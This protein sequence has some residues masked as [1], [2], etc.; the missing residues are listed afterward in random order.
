MHIQATGFAPS[1]TS[2]FLR[3]IQRNFALHFLAARTID[4]FLFRNWHQCQ[5]AARPFISG[6]FDSVWTST[7]TSPS[8]CRNYHAPGTVYSWKPDLSLLFTYIIFAFPAS[9]PVCTEVIP[10]ARS[11][12][13]STALA[14]AHQASS[15]AATVCGCD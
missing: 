14:G 1:T 10:K 7:F 11:G 9:P 8:G 3:C 6:P 2:T 4:C 15:W 12:V 5:T 13:K